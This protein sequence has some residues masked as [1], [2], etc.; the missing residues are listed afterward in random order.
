MD[1][2][3]VK[4]LKNLRKVKPSTSWLE[5]QRSF[6]ISEI[7]KTDSPIAD[8]PQE[9]KRIFAFPVF[10]ISRFFKPVFALAMVLIVFVSSLGTIGIISAAQNSLPGDPLYALKTAFEQ[11]QMSLASSDESR[12]VLSIKFASQRIDE[13]AQITNNPEKK[14]DIEKTVQNLTDQLVAAQENMDKLKEKNSEKAVEVAKLVSDQID[15]YKQ[16]LI[17]AGDQLAYLMP[18]EKPKLDQAFIEVNKLQEKCDELKNETNTET[19]TLLEATEETVIS[20]SPSFEEIN[21]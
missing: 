5:S 2:F 10:N 9:R 16:N 20:P 15:G 13:F 12:V 6:L 11:T 1:E 18:E 21:E 3:I 7:S 14:S 19:D 4:Q 17:K 8:V